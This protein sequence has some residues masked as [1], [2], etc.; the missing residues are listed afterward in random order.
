MAVIAEVLKVAKKQ[1]K[2]WK[3]EKR[4]NLPAEEELKQSE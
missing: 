2:L 1:I 4:Q 3:E